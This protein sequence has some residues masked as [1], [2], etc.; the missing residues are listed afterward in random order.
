MN[1]S[2][3]FHI[4]FQKTFSYALYYSKVF[5]SF[6]LSIK[7]IDLFV[8]MP[9]WG[10]NFH[11]SPALI[12]LRYCKSLSKI[13]SFII[14]KNKYLANRNRKK[15]QVLPFPK[16]RHD[17]IKTFNKRPVFMKSY[18]WTKQMIPNLP[19]FNFKEKCGK[20]LLG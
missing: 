5:R 3:I 11:P 10:V 6:L 1:F 9:D 12:N 17:S 16:A 13:R 19:K 15:K 14:T 18:W 8:K 4:C 20:G 7:V 2:T